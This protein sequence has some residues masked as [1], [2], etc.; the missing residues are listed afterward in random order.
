MILKLF[1]F[2][3]WIDR[4]EGVV[5]IGSGSAVHNLRLYQTYPGDLPSPQ[6]V[7]DF[8]NEMEMIACNLKVS[9]THYKNFFLSWLFKLILQRKKLCMKLK[10]TKLSFIKWIVYCDALN[11][12]FF[13]F[14]CF[15]RAMKGKAQ[16]TNW[17]KIEIFEIA[18]PPQSI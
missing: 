11:N 8:D 1:F 14:W 18:I 10:L 15:I 5:I 12:Y 2:S 4:D 6:F 3:W 9:N 16:R 13:P 7:M 17:T